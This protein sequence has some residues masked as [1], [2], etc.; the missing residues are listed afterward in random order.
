M[1][2]DLSRRVLFPLVIYTGLSDTKNMNRKGNT[3][4]LVLSLLLL[5]LLSGLV[6]LLWQ[7]H[8]K[9]YTNESVSFK[10]P[11]RW[12][13]E[14][15]HA[16]YTNVLSLVFKDIDKTPVLG[17]VFA[18]NKNDATN[19]PFTL[20]E[21]LPDGR[22]VMVADH[23]AR[24]YTRKEEAGYFPSESVIIDYP[25]KGQRIHLDFYAPS[26]EPNLGIATK[27]LFDPLLSTFSFASNK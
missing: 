23:Q 12:E 16:L 21:L 3:L 20:K 10:Y 2:D 8:W 1:S 22:E 27:K 6:Y 17:V 15:Y 24:R 7:N 26:S 19:K 11:Q 25:E 18:I 13:L 4:V 14:T 5:V 9:T